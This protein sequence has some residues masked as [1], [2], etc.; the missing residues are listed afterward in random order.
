MVAG[1]E[2]EAV[3]KAVRNGY[4][5]YDRQLTDDKGW[6]LMVEETYVRGS[7]SDKN[8]KVERGPPT[9]VTRHGKD[10][11][12]KNNSNVLKLESTRFAVK[13]RAVLQKH[14]FQHITKL[15]PLKI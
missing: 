14:F 6:K 10:Q 15:G 13:I 11:N 2:E 8:S 9:M 1:A 7:D 3:S 5:I 4:K 12:A